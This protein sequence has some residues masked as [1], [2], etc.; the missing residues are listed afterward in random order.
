MHML[1]IYIY[2]MF[3][4]EITFVII[5]G[6]IPNFNGYCVLIMVYDWPYDT[7]NL[8]FILGNAKVICFLSRVRTIIEFFRNDSI[9]T[10]ALLTNPY[11]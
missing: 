9:I 3:K 7:R 6:I 4:E 2:M 8:N 5:L 1:Y 10:L 11:S